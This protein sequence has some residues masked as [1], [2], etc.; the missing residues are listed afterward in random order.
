M[1]LTGT[2]YKL[3]SRHAYAEIGSM[4]TGLEADFTFEV[5]MA[6]INYHFES[7]LIQTEIRNFFI[8][9]SFYIHN[10]QIRKRF[11]NTRRLY[12]RFTK[13]IVPN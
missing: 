1:D 7:R 6:G 8:E 12:L 5:N 3:G 9:L 10:L 13:A 2:S 4:P 11:H